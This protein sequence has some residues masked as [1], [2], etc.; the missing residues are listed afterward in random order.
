MTCLVRSSEKGAQVAKDYPK[1]RLVYGNLDSFDL[2]A[3]ESAKAHIVCNFA[4]CNHENSVK[5]IAKGMTS[6]GDLGYYVH[7]SGAG[8][9]TELDVRAN[10]VGEKSEKVYD[11]WDNI[12]EVT[13]LPDEAWHRAVDKIVLGASEMSSR[14]KTAIVCPPTIYGPGRGPGNTYSD[15]C[16]LLAKAYI[17]CGHAFSIG[18]GQNMW[19]NIHVH[20]LSQLYLTLVEEAGKSRD[21]STPCLY[22][23]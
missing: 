5:A 17:Q 7:T 16:Y 13:S 8:I 1:A 10:R 12:G 18:N 21:P 11:D 22:A 15:Q 23:D 6:R 20:D 14:I 4:D 2:L 9:L 3:E 19:T